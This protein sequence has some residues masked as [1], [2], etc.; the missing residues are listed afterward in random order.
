M[1][2]LPIDFDDRSST[3]PVEALPKAVEGVWRVF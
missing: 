1:A 3:T 2:T